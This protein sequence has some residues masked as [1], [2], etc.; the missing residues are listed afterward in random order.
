[1]GMALVFIDPVSEQDEGLY[2]CQISYHHHMAKV[3][4]RV[5]VT[6]EETQHMIFIIIC[7]SS[8]SAITLILMIVL[9]VLCKSGRSH[10][11]QK[12]KNRNERESL[13]ALMQDPRS[14]ERMVIPGTAGPHYAELV[15]YSIV[16]DAKSTV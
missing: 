6:S 5:E 13:A 12:K 16:F 4:I 14:P 11:S 3:F 10:T 2:I 9:I 7:F 1:M 15:H 8:A